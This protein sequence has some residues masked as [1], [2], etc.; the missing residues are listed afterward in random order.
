MFTIVSDDSD[1]ET[2]SEF[3]EIRESLIQDPKRARMRTYL[4]KDKEDKAIWTLTRAHFGTTHTDPNNSPPTAIQFWPETEKKRTS[5]TVD[6][7]QTFG[8]GQSVGPL[9]FCGHA[10]L[11]TREFAT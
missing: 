3:E 7:I 5:S 2:G 6:Y 11:I 10:Q 8:K 9:A 4:Y 1:S